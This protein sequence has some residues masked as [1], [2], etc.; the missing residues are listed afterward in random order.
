[1]RVLC[2]SAAAEADA[3]AAKKSVDSLDTLGLLDVAEG[4]VK[5]SAGSGIGAGTDAVAGFFG[6]STEGANAIASLKTIAGQ[7]ISKMPRM[8][9]PQ[10]DKDVQLY[11]DM[12]GNLSDPM[13]P[14]P[15]LLAA[16]ETIRLLNERSAK[17]PEPA[18]SGKEPGGE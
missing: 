9:G 17:P 4:V 6:K 5:Q 18:Q 13:T 16:L 1:M 8:E 12:A 15:Q 3:T 11:K 7:L 2:R 14:L 10:S